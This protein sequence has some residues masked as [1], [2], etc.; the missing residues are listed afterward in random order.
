M[1]KKKIKKKMFSSSGKLSDL[2][3]KKFLNTVSELS[4]GIETSKLYCVQTRGSYFIARIAK[5]FGSKYSDISKPQKFAT[6]SLGKPEIG[7]F[8]RFRLNVDK[9]R[10]Q[11]KEG[12]KVL[13]L[14]PKS[15]TYSDQF[16]PGTI[17]GKDTISDPAK[18]K[19]K[20]DSGEEFFVSE[21]LIVPP[22]SEWEK[23]QGSTS[24]TTKSTSSAP[25]KSNESSS[26]DSDSDS[27]NSSSSYSEHSS[28]SYSYSSSSSSD[29]SSY[30]RRHRRGHGHGHRGHRRNIIIV[31][32]IVTYPSFVQQPYP[33]QY[34]PPFYY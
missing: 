17:I 25:S 20:F 30:R 21:C 14:Q 6:V 34:Q 11:F 3:T 28:S 33:M 32:I 2:R 19:V 23:A 5:T 26:K 12:S 24:T 1:I 27:S 7:I 9:P 4:R 22:E 29:Y 13:S 31:P 18:Y 15:G 8:P 10:L 16:Y